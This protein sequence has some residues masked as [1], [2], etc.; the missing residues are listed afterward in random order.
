MRPR[1]RRPRCASSPTTPTMRRRPSCSPTTAWRGA[2]R[3]PGR[4]TSPAVRCASTRSTMAGYTRI[5]GTTLLAA[6]LSGCVTGH[7]WQ[8]GRRWERPTTFEQ[9]SVDGDRLV[10]QYAAQVTDDDGVPIGER[11][12]RAALP[13]ASLPAAGHAAEDVRMHPLDDAGAMPG[14]SVGLETAPLAADGAPVSLVVH[15]PRV[16]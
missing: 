6:L 14:T 13:L 8:A 9:A 15:D 4:S 1:R 7:V 12:R 10:V 2:S 11:T 5:A 16:P 3:I